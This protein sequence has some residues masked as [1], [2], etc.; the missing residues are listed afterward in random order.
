MI[1]PHEKW[2]ALG[3]ALGVSQV[4][5]KRED[6]HPYGS[7]KGRSI[8][9][10]IDLYL[11]E[12]IGHFVISSSGNSA[13][14]AAYH[15][16]KLNEERN[17]D[18][19]ITL[20]IFLGKHIK[21]H[22]HQK[23]EDA[24]D[25]NILTS[26]QDRPLQTVFTRAKDETIKPLR[27]SNDDTALLGYETLA[28]ELLEIPNLKAVFIGTSSGTTAQALATYFIKNKKEIE[29]HIV[30]TSS[31]H[32]ISN[33]FV[34]DA[35]DETDSLADAIVDQSARRKDILVP[36]ITKTGGSGWIAQNEQIEIALELVKKHTGLKISPNSAL[37]VV[38][39]MEASYTGRSWDGA[40]ACIIG[41]E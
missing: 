22:K 11:K 30:Q 14:A 5:F 20:E 6:L 13:L 2:D 10:M 35:G 16:R 39:L 41:G 28:K 8:P 36:L 1:T 27:Q 12:G 17:E 34:D 32:P 7:H 19:K 29:V 15:V 40:V 18:E 25:S 24:K 23:I 33:A 21:P 37:S 38:G 3:E 4:F 26:I 9:T 31:C